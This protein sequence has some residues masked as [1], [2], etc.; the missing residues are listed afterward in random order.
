VVTG[1]FGIS[2]ALSAKAVLLNASAIA[3]AVEGSK[4]LT[5]MGRDN[6]HLR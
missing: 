5:L 6:T 1:F 2:G 4:K 3:V